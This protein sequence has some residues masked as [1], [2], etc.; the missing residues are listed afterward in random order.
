[1]KRWLA[2]LLVATAAWGGGQ[3]APPAP[4]SVTQ[5]ES[6]VSGDPAGVLREARAGAAMLPPQ[7]RARRLPLLVRQVVA[8]VALEHNDEAA[9]VLPEAEA[10]ARQLRARD[11]QCVLQNMSLYLEHESKG[12]ARVAE[13]AARAVQEARASTE[14]WCVPR[15]L[16]TLL[17]IHAKDGRRATALG[18]GQEAE[19]MFVAA[20]ETLMLATVRSSLSSVLRERGDDADSVRRSVELAAQAVTGLDP[21]HHRYQ[22]ASSLHDLVGARIAAKDWQ[23][24]RRDAAQAERLL[25]A[26]DMP[27]PIR[28]LQGEIEL[29]DGK[30]AQAPPY[31][32]EARIDQLVVATATME[33]QALVELHRPE[34]ALV[35]LADAALRR[36]QLALPKTDV[37]YFRVAMEVRAAI[38]D[39]AGTATAARSYADALQRRL[40]EENHRRATELQER[41]ASAQKEA[42]NRLLRGQQEAQRMRMLALVALL[43]L[44]ALVMAGLGVLVVHQRRQR[45]RLKRLAE[46]DELTGLPNRRAILDILNDAPA[47]QRGGRAIAMLD[48]DHFKRVNDRHGH[49]AGD[50]ALVTFAKVCSGLLREGDVMGRLGGEEFLL[51]FHRAR[52]AELQ[53]L[54]ER[55]RS[56]LRATPIPGMPV[57][58]RISF[59]MGT[60]DL[61][62]QTSTEAALAAADEALYRAKSGGRDRMEI[63]TV[64]QL[65]ATCWAQAPVAG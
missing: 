16:A 55:M 4:Q 58:E 59:S 24:A 46:V 43:A 36:E 56:A 62:A 61:A 21:Q 7:A 33:A 18:V 37:P 31:S 51:V 57:E 26:L 41:Y 17:M 29:P 39:A 20:G 38:R 13:K 49:A 54:F 22:I 9:A 47:H 30:P 3:G 64:P 6:D 48:I 42:E 8:A 65:V 53:P 44:A 23:G 45:V 52:A 25:H 27:A 11:M 14:T 28:R 15:L 12:W 40:K 32:R 60:V 19:A 34:Q 5:I 50:A 35:V 2:L 10:L 63:G 1:M